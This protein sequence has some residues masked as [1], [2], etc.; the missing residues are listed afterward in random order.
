MN[1]GKRIFQDIGKY[2]ISLR[3]SYIQLQKFIHTWCIK[4]FLFLFSI[5]RLVPVHSQPE[6]F[7][8]IRN[9]FGEIQDV[10]DA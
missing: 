8:K 3:N 6:L 7:I 10:S 4:S 9:T 5:L 1:S 2:F